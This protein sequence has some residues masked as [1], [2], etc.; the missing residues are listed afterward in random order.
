MKRNTVKR[1]G[2]RVLS[3]ALTLLLFMQT[4]P[5]ATFAAD[6][7]EPAGIAVEVTEPAQA[8]ISE[9]EDTNSEEK[10]AAEESAI[11]E[12]AEEETA[13]ES[14][15]VE[16][17]AEEAAN[18]P[19]AAE[20]VE[21]KTA[22][23]ESEE[24][25]NETEKEN[26]PQVEQADLYAQLNAAAKGDIQITRAEQLLNGVPAGSTYVL[27]NDLIMGADQ[28]IGVVAGVLDGAGHTITLSGKPL[29]RELTGT[30]QNLLVDG[31]ATLDNGEGSIVCTINGGTLQNCASTVTIDPGWAFSL[32]GLAGNLENARIYNSYFAGTGKDMFGIVSNSGI[33]AE[34][35]N[36]EAPSKIKNCYYSE[37]TNVGIGLSW[38]RD[39]AS[40]GIKSLDIMKTPEFVQ[41]LNASNVGSGYIWEDTEGALPK[42]VPGG[43]ELE[44]ADKAA[45]EAV[46]KEAQSKNES[47]YTNETWAEMKKALDAAKK[48]NEKID[49]VQEEV[50]EAVKTLQNALASL[51]EKVRDLSPV[52]SPQNGVIPISSPE[53][54]ARIDGSN[55][56]VFYQLT[57]DI[58]IEENFRSPN[59]AG[60]L[61]G[62]GHNITIC[63]PRSLFGTITETG[64][65]Q[66]LSVK[67]EGN[68]TNRQE[69]A[70][71]AE[72]L[73]GGMIVNCISELTGQHSTGYVRK[74]EGGVLV[75]C[76][77]MGHNRRGAFVYF[78]KSTDHQNINGYKSGQFYNCYW[79]ASNS[80]ENINP[81]ENLID[82]EP[83]GDERLRSDAFI[84]QLNSQKGE[85]G[86]VWGRD[87]NGYPYF[88]ADQGDLVIDGSKNRYDV[89]F[90]WHNQQILNVENGNLQLS[91]QMTNGNRFAGTFQLKDVPEDSTI[92]WS[93]EDRSNQEIMQLTENG[94][95]YVFHDGGGVVRAVEH[96]ADGTQETAAEIRVVSA[97]R[98]IEELRLL[99][100][101]K[102]IVDD[103]TVQGSAVN[104]LEVQAKYTGS[105]TFQTMPSYLVE[106]T[107]ENPGL[108]CTE[109]NVASF[110]FKKPGTSK[111]TVT[112]KTAK[113]NPVSITVS[114][115]SEYVP[116]KSV[117]PAISDRV[118]IHYRNSMGSGQ[119][120]SLPQ[121]VF[122]E[123]SNAS[124]KNDIA[125]E[126]SD[127][128]IAEYDGSGYI[129]YKNGTVTFTAKLNDNGKTVEGTSE[130]NFV[131]TNPLTKVQGPKEKITLDQGMTQ[132]LPL[133]F[134]GQ[135]GNLH[136]ITEPNL[137]W[138]FDK[139][140]IISIRRPDKLMQIR[141]TGGLD[142]G[143]WVASKTFEVRGLRPGTVVATGTPVDTTGGAT[144][145]KLTITVNG[146]GSEVSG[147]DIPGFIKTGK[148]TASGYLNANNTYAFGE[149]WSIYTLLRDGQTLP[150][151]RLDSYYNDVVTNV[152]S[153]SANILATEVERTAMALNIM[154]KDITDVDGVNLVEMICDH[155]NLTKQG[156]NSLV[157][158]LIALD[159]NNT[160]IPEDMTWSRER[161]IAELLT[162]QN[163]DGG[164]GLDKTGTSGV[165][166]TA[167]C[168]QALAH[169]RTNGEVAAAIERGVGYLAKAVERNPNL[170]NSESLSQ[171]IIAL[172]VL[173][174][175]IIAE[176]GFGDE[177]ENVMSAL[178]EYMVE[179]V[180]FRH[181]R[182]GEVDKMATAQAMQALCAYERFLNGESSY[183]D[184]QGTGPVEDPAEEVNSMIA[185]LP[186]KITLDYAQAVKAA[187]AAYDA[188]T[189]A[190]KARVKNLE[191]L[192]NAERVLDVLQM[193]DALPENVT[194]TDAY[195]VKLA[196]EAYDR[197]T[198]KQQA[199]ITNY[200]KLEAAEA[201][202]KKMATE[203]SVMEMIDALPENIT[204]ADENAIRAA[205]AAYDLLTWDQQQKVNNRDKLERAENKLE[206]LISA[207]QVQQV[208]DA[209]NALP[210]T[211]TIGDEAAVQAVRIAYNQLK[212]AQKAQISNVQKLL[213]AEKSI[214]DQKA[215][216]AVEKAIKM[217]PDPVS[218]ADR[219]AVQA[220]RRAYDALSAD[221]QALVHNL[222]KLTKAEEDIKDLDAAQEV[223]MLIKNL[224]VDITASDAPAVQ[225]ARDAYQALTEKQQALVLNLYMLE[226]TEQI[227]AEKKAVQEVEDAINA[228]PENI[229]QEDG[230]A[231][232]AARAAY[233]DL[234]PEL[235]KQ[236]TNLDKLIQAEKALKALRK[237]AGK[238]EKV[239]KTESNVVEAVVE[240]GVVSAKQL[241]EIQGKDL[242]LRIEGMM[243][244]GE[245]YILSIYGKDIAKVED[246]HME[247]K[248]EGLYETEIHKLSEN[249]EIFRFMETGA[250]PGPVMVEMDTELADGEYLLLHYDPDEQRASLVSRVTVE[251]GRV[252]F[253]V[254]EGGE[255]FLAKKASKKSIPELE[256]EMKPSDEVQPNNQDAAKETASEEVISVQEEQ[257]NG[258]NILIWMPLL[259]LVV[260]GVIAALK[261]RKENKG[262]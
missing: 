160:E 164:F 239:I 170:G 218:L 32:G 152:H 49:A 159:M 191:K 205:R 122:V 195:T 157:W 38:N 82:C 17:A 247:M 40:N 183:W 179:G 25:A 231:V 19:E 102:V 11:A 2:Q 123:P 149:E 31:K 21:Q 4:M 104:T 204:L 5:L 140:G 227:V 161:M 43:S 90:V 9:T 81:A 60:V 125:V 14:A 1:T 194:L 71:Y 55:P 146:D 221:Q 193:I 143:N 262:E 260:V 75:N 154:G 67:T 95:L 88:G 41:L 168:I 147:F 85:F 30:I 222:D 209:I 240:N 162:Y 131:Y 34:S 121:A 119:F 20:P 78:Q 86:A 113:E 66:N 138:T 196:R 237:S 114:I 18:E 13:N 186:E 255:Y 116:A 93:C 139:K 259:L 181:S 223:M 37:G 42:L 244:T 69:F 29:A 214:A 15:V 105:D 208:I 155:P 27:A 235:R 190:Q 167:M 242:I 72:M 145:V 153:W 3:L 110:Y 176:P 217:L 36:Q 151:N 39:D 7:E 258:V 98:E 77:T 48:A 96:K 141:N 232:K 58:V 253:I 109:Y 61:D 99:L 246:F 180:G 10:A 236:V 188:L 156:S 87:A 177:M 73:K 212:E 173:E 216:A 100:D 22:E 172:A 97:S 68:F 57:R 249:P 201:A 70:P 192:V 83:V 65:V 257:E 215:A 74:M 144:P 23:P 106:L 89:Q 174:R 261:K 45:L 178:S 136:E 163:K 219:Q 46:I 185:A 256:E 230:E 199:Q 52:E 198:W 51:E 225:A 132:T 135:P 229:T 126:S 6:A 175:D 115:T 133:T 248:R 224:P 26:I 251:N 129:P 56:D 128:S 92:R 94:Q 150:Q 142:D 134:Y 50:D 171:V 91:P 53:E 62:N 254:E 76:L 184:L 64:V 12:P 112:E 158:A 206:E 238:P 213:N 127:P 108:L 241:A 33:F 187:R 211:V 84:A 101:G 165:D 243:E 228:L 245:E 210:E 35:R 182:N 252:Q 220:A 107:S 80:V 233:N 8:V 63:A 166:M 197:L 16:S 169:Y 234:S 189:E 124:Y 137:I 120:I 207:Q 130:V 111:L 202:L 200:S 103:V 79:S 148:K 250:F 47:N 28:Q 118:E 54:L 59:L 44:P 226:R 117:K 24:T 203:D